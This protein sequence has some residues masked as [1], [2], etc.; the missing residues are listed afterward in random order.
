MNKKKKYIIL[1]AVLILAVVLIV[2]A[3]RNRQREKKSAE[4]MIMPERIIPVEAEKA[5]MSVMSETVEGIGDVEPLK[6]VVV[7]TEA[8]GVL[9]KLTVREGDFVKAGQVIASI[10]GRQREL[11]VQQL[12]NEIKAQEYQLDNI[13]S[14][15]ER[16]KRLS[17]E[18]VVSS[19]KFEDIETLYNAEF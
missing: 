2:S 8:T 13:K 12:E 3:A 7:Y 16:Y 17:D 18:G 4:K 14:D 10:E 19:K 1:V 5:G 15:Y 6:K 11:A 9:E